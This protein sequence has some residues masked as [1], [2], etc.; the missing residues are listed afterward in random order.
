MI[1]Y[2]LF[3]GC[4]VFAFMLKHLVPFYILYN[5]KERG[6]Q[7][8]FAVSDVNTLYWSVVAMAVMLGVLFIYIAR[9]LRKIRLKNT[10]IYTV[11]KHIKVLLQQHVQR[12]LAIDDIERRHFNE[13]PTL[14]D[15][16]KP[17]NVNDVPNPGY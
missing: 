13:L 3:I 17:M 11:N 6:A 1:F 8:G 14:P 12:K 5:L 9:V 4:I 10:I 16:T 7:S 2:C 15:E